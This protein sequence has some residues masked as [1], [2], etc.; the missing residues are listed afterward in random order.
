M[1]IK[2]NIISLI[3]EVAD[4]GV[5]KIESS[6][7]DCVLCGSNKLTFES[8]DKIYYVSLK[9][10]EVPKVDCKDCIYNSVMNGCLWDFEDY[11]SSDKIT[12]IYYEGVKRCGNCDYSGYD[13]DA[14]EVCLHSKVNELKQD[15][16]DMS[17]V[18]CE[19][20]KVDV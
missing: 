11:S 16:D 17:E 13:V 7:K 6:E 4:T 9:V 18:E 2:S 15:F 8:D 1:N 14:T 5:S 20:W 19:Y 3:R 10:D 12:C